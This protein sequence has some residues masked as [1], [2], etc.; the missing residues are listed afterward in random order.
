MNQIAK[1]KLEPKLNGLINVDI[2]DSERLHVFRNILAT[3]DRS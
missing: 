3:I 1:Q 2:T